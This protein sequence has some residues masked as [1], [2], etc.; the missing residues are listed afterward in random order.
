MLVSPPK[1]AQIQDA[2]LVSFDI[3]DTLLGRIVASPSDVFRFMEADIAKLLGRTISDFAILRNTSEQE[4]KE[5]AQKRG[6]DD[7]TLNEIYTHLLL[8]LNADQALLQQI[9]EIELNWERRCT[10][11]R[12]PGQVLFNLARRLHKDIV[13]VSDMYLPKSFIEELLATH[14]YSGYLKLYISCEYGKSKASGNIFEVV[15][16]DFAVA[17]DEILHIG[18]NENGDVAIPKRLGIKP[19]RLPRSV[20]QLNNRYSFGRSIFEGAVRTNRTL[21]TSVMTQQIADFIFDEPDVDLEGAFGGD[22]FAFGYAL[23]GP[24]LLGYVT[25]LHAEAK[26]RGI[27]RLL[28]LSR[29]GQLMQRAY[30]AIF[31]HQALPNDYIFASRQVARICSLGSDWD[32]ERVLDE[33]I[34]ATKLSDFLEFRFGLSAEELDLNKLYELGYTGSEMNIGNKVDRQAL[35]ELVFHHRSIIIKRAEEQRSRYRAYLL[36]HIGTSSNVAVVDIGYAGTMQASI[37]RLTGKQIAGFYL[38]TTS[39]VLEFSETIGKSFAYI[40]SF[41]TSNNNPTLGIHKYRFLYET[42][43]CSA[44]DS[45]EGFDLSIEEVKPKQWKN[46]QAKNRKGFVKLAHAGTVRFCQDIMRR[47]PRQEYTF[48]LTGAAAS[49]PLD[50]FLRAPPPPDVKLFEDIE[51]EDRYGPSI[52]RVFIASQRLA[53]MGPVVE[54][55]QEG[56]EVRTKAESKVRFEGQRSGKPTLPIETVYEFDSGF[57]LKCEGL[58]MRYVLSQKLLKKYRKDRRRFFSDSQNLIWR[59]YGRLTEKRLRS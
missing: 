32:I 43:I 30:Q 46:S 51:F 58:L 49:L 50:S 53:K 57:A 20:E 31:E 56:V 2:K 45:F 33:Q 25:W 54:L 19:F 14:G 48:H 37:S 34:Y 40:D 39:K 22:P 17:Y 36:K 52:K 27:D 41:A 26:A 47:W 5:I 11:V 59:N 15:A 18:D 23:L 16:T 44:E 8:R 7:I 38:A 4:V 21:S 28:F 12:S 3:F 35:R 1:I 55:W 29:D 9:C 6:I 10:S 13:L 42:L 24:L